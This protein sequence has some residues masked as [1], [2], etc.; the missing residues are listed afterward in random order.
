VPK[1][2]KDIK[3]VRDKINIKK[4]AR[5]YVAKNGNAKEAALIANPNYKPDSAKVRG[6]QLL[7]RPDVQAEI[8]T[9][10]EDTGI[11]YKYVLETRKEL[12]DKGLNQSRN[13][14]KLPKNGFKDVEVSPKDINSHLLGIEAIMKRIGE[15]KVGRLNNTYHQHLHL[16]NKT[17]VELLERRKELQS[18]FDG[19]V[20]DNN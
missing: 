5:A 9:A 16:E 4:F 3:K 6:N 15:D 20:T 11:N 2:N 12:V 1:L 10:L 8:I 19:V 14:I 7:K 18:F 13:G 17:P